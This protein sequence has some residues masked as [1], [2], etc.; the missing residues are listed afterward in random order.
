LVKTE[1]QSQNLLLNSFF[2]KHCI[3]VSA[4][5]ACEEFSEHMKEASSCK[6]CSGSRS[7]AVA[8]AAGCGLDD[9]EVAV[10]GQ[11]ILG[12]FSSKE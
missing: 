5:N 12:N 7:K 9:L 4:A 10:Y 8:T 11:D 2:S 6:C 3:L 1:L